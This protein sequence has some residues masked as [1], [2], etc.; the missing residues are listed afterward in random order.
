MTDRAI[1]Q[2]ESERPNTSPEPAECWRRLTPLAVLPL[3]I[4]GAVDLARQGWQAFAGMAAA[5]HFTT[6][7]RGLLWLWIGLGLGILLIGGGILQWW[8][9][10]YAVDDRAIR[11]RRG[12]FARQRL[13]LDFAR[14]QNLRITVPI[15]L[16]PFGLVTLALDSA[17]SRGAEIVLPAV[18]RALAEDIAYRV[19]AAQATRVAAGTDPPAEAAKAARRLDTE[20][21]SSPAAETVLV[22]RTAHDLI[23]QGLASNTAWVVAGVLAS[24][25]AGNPD[26]TGRMVVALL[27]VLLGPLDDLSWMAVAGLVAGGLAVMLVALLLLSILGSLVHFHGFV[28]VD[29]GRAWRARHGLLERREVVVA[30]TKLQALSLRQTLIG[31]LVGVWELRFHQAGGLGASRQQ[32]AARRQKLVIPAVASPELADILA[33]LMPGIPWPLPVVRKPHP[34]LIAHGMRYLVLLGGGAGG[35]LAA[36]LFHRVATGWA[37]GVGMAAAAVLVG[38]GW[39]VLWRLRQ[40]RGHAAAPDLVITTHGFLGQRIVLFRPF[41]TQW[42]RLQAGP[43]LRRRQL[44][45]LVIAL[46]G[47]RTQIVYL[48]AGDARALAADLLHQAARDPRPWY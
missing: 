32:G 25:F 14:V 17:G 5:V 37:L 45:H 29:E 43:A 47:L 12:V 33:A 11:L 19:R 6:D 41:K 2:N 7:D 36:A 21:A 27:G 26:R 46:A 4:K 20:A 13:H 8:H 35:G 38:L 15:Y 24:L 30:K 1:P 34:F 22:R 10:R 9:F 18:P 40:A 42:V 3:V 28:L 48:P 23:R 39:L 31:R 16:R 44:A